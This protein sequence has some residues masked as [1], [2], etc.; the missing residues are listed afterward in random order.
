MRLLLPVL[1]TCNNMG[2]A[3]MRHLH[4]YLPSHDPAFFNGPV[5]QQASVGTYRLG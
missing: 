5:I 3:A 4:D 2:S 1:I